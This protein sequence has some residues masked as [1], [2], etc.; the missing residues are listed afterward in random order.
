MACHLNTEADALKIIKLLVTH[1]YFAN[2]SRIVDINAQD[3]AGNT[4]LHHAAHSCKLSVVK[5]LIEELGVK[6]DIKNSED[7]LP[8]DMVSRDD[9]E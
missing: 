9:I 4:C 6:R 5:Y 8:I 7:S 1:R 2:Q 3:L